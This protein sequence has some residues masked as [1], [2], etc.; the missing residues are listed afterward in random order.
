MTRPPV[1]RPSPPPRG[2]QR[3]RPTPT[4]SSPTGEARDATT[5]A[6]GRD[7]PSSRCGVRHSRAGGAAQ[8]PLNRPARCRHRPR[9]RSRRTNRCNRRHRRR[10]PTD[11]RSSSPPSKERGRHSPW[12]RPSMGRR[13][14]P[15][16]TVHR[17]SSSGAMGWP[18]SGCRALVASPKTGRSGA[19]DGC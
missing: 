2:G 11:Q 6:S 13:R 16:V 12:Q 17:S 15:A 14:R 9:P 10:R 5:V 8:S 1:A 4:S 3:R 7:R 19:S 18:T